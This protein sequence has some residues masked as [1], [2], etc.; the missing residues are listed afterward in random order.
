MDFALTPEQEAIR[1]TAQRFAREK[2]LPSYQACARSGRLDRA[3]L[4]EMGSLGLIAPD[5]PEDFGGYGLDGLTSGLIVEAL[6]YGDFNMAYVPLLTGLSGRIVCDHATPALAQQW[7]PKLVAGEALIGLALTEPR[8]GSDAAN[9]QL[10]AEPAGN[11]AYR[12]NGEKTS[13]SI[14]DQADVFVVFAR[15]GKPDE[16]ARG[17]SAFLVPADLPGLTR[18]RFDDFGSESV[19]RGSL[20]FDDVELP[21]ENLLGR[22]GGG[23]YQV[24]QGFDYSRA[25]IGLQCI[26][27]AQAS[28]D[29]S[30]AHVQERETFGRPLAQY[31]GVSFP[32]AEGETLLAAARLL[33]YET[34]WLRD[35]GKPH[36]D[37]A[38]MCKWFAP[39]TAADV[40]HNCLL[41]H[42][43]AGYSKD[44]PHQQ[45]LRDVI[46]LEIGD[47]T[48]QIS[49]LIIARERIGNIA[50]Q[51]R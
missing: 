31:Q 42:G 38:A 1:E 18:T 27:A 49:K 26:A 3:L 10:K 9:L 44:S 2:L 17:V 51:Y 40:I 29:E 13:I 16:G 24:M 5:L 32:L 39:K 36:T 15:T 19:G 23:F 33:C 37:K 21:A 30:W 22:E 35:Q 34:L 20:F 46:G 47:G 7:V 45:R 28:L 14:A 43:H 11:A 6:A 4:R 25:L 50:V 12:I 48:A 8:G 41:V